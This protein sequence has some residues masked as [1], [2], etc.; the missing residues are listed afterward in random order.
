MSINP[1]QAK[2][3]LEFCRQTIEHYKAKADH[4]KSETL[5]CFILV[6]VCTLTTPLF[7]TLGP[8]LWLGK[9]APSVL[10]LIAAGATA[11]LQQRK[12]Q[13]LWS[14]YRTAQRELECHEIRYSYHIEE[15]EEPGNP[16]KTLAKN[17]A[18]IILNTHRQWIPMVP[19]P[20]SLNV[21]KEGQKTHSQLSRSSNQLHDQNKV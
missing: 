17:V 4:N 3:P 1:E 15:Y 9:V 7:I 14:L 16:E 12:P 5:R 13:Q 20:D 18:S 2:D 8:G 6:I 11:W 10:S 21:L 19:A